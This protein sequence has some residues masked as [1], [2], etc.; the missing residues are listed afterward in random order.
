MASYEHAGNPFPHGPYGATGDRLWVREAHHIDWYPTGILD[1]H[2]RPG[3]A[4]Y[5]ADRDTI[6]QSW[7]ASTWRSSI[8]MPRWA[9]RLIL[10]VEMIEGQRLQALSENDVL[11]EGIVWSGAQSATDAFIAAWNKIYAPGRSQVLSWAANPWVW[12]I[13]FSVASMA[14][15]G[16]VL[17]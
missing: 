4:H 7:P 3:V 12:K 17:S 15:R 13:Q 10:Q 14:K 6:S 8:Y 16:E 5:R 2:G 9:C 1:S 11:A